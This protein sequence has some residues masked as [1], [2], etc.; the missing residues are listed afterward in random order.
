MRLI[1]SIAILALSGCH[2]IKPYEKEFLLNPVMD[3][4][5]ISA[6]TPEM[7]GSKCQDIEKLSAAGPGGASSSCPTC[8]G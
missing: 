2:T 1:M 4:A 7:L 5:V 3:D 6:L 8:G